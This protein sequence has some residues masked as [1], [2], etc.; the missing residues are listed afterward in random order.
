MTEPHRCYRGPRCV[1]YEKDA[2]NPTLRRGAPINPAQG[3]CDTCERHLHR[4]LIEMPRDYID[5]ETALAG[6]ND[7]LRQLV[8]GTP[9]PPI[10]ISLAIATAQTDILHEA[11]C[12]AESVAD[13]RGIWWDTQAARD[14]RPGPVIA[15]ASRLLANSLS[16]LLALRGVLHT[17]WTYGEWHVVERDGTDGALVLLDLHHRARALAGH[18]RLISRL[19]TPCPNCQ[20]AA[21]HHE[22]GSD[23]VTCGACARRCSLDDYDD[24]CGLA[25]GAECAA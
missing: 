8:G 17:Q 22:D 13:I 25:T 7:G 18:T 11:H 23:T 19:P 1:K 5:L 12:W 24:I 16:V 21:L 9:E 10:P 15:R 20:R 14:A 6:R 3:L 4:A 2:T